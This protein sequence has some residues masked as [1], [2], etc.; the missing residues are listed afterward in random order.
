[1]LKIQ[2]LAEKLP[3]SDIIAVSRNQVLANQ[4]LQEKGI[5]TEVTSSESAQHKNM[6]TKTLKENIRPALER[7]YKEMRPRISYC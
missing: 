1:M 4:D 5:Q 3:L 6:Q 2:M 7:Q